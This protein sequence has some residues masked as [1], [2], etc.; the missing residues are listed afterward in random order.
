MLMRGSSSCYYK[1]YGVRQIGE[2]AGSSVCKWRRR[3]PCTP[4]RKGMTGEMKLG[5]G[6][7]GRAKSEGQMSEFAGI[8]RKGKNANRR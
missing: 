1:Y 6:I 2:A 4:E 3:P 7:S 5:V 8:L